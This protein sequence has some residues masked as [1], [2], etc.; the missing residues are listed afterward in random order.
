L[1]GQTGPVFTVR[2]ATAADMPA[3]SAIYNATIATTTAAWTEIPET[4]EQRLA[5][6]A[7]HAV[8]GHPV[9]VADDDGGVLGFSAFGDFRDT[10]K[11]PGYRFVV[12]HTIHVGEAAWGRGVG[13]AL[14][15]AL[16]DR[17]RL[18]GKTQMVAAVDGANAGSVE[19]HRRLGFVE[20]GR[21]P[22][23]GFKF[24]GWLDLL[25]LQRSTAPRPGV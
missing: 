6:F 4:V 7:D 15:T 1:I 19:F 2:D 23:V 14:M 20:V 18:L 8:A 12:E 25:L 10:T 11:W 17:A 24:G 13:R 9:L 3:V 16:I 22:A 5:W 21:M